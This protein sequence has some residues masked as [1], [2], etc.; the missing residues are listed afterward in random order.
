M[1]TTSASHHSPI[2][3]RAIAKINPDHVIRV[4]GA[5]YK[6][7]LLLEGIADVYVYPSWGCKLWDIAGPHALL[8]A[9][10]GMYFCLSAQEQKTL[11]T[12]TFQIIRQHCLLRFIGTITE[13]W[14]APIVYG[15]NA[16]LRLD[17][18]FIVSVR[19]HDKYLQLLRDLK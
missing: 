5:G 8:S 14:G 7:L 6:S 1:L 17:R 18:G 12:K 16:D 15:P 9:I 10:G 3:D 2:I 11:S 4:G 13:P 19:N